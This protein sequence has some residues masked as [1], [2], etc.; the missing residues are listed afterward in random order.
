MN[1]EPILLHL[2]SS[3]FEASSDIYD[4]R[5]VIRV[6][7]DLKDQTCQLIHFCVEEFHCLPQ[8]YLVDSPKYGQLAHVIPSMEY[9]NLGSICVN[10]LDSVSVN[11][12]RPELAFEESLTRH[13]ALLRKL[14][15]DSDFNNQ[16][17]LR[18]YQSNWYLC[19]EGLI[20]GKAKRVVF[21]LSNRDFEE[22]QVY[23]SIDKNSLASLSASSIAL[24]RY[25]DIKVMQ[26]LS[27]DDRR[28]NKD[29]ICFSLPLEGMEPFVPRTKSEMQQW[30]ITCLGNVS[31]DVKAEFQ[32]N[33]SNKRS[34]EFWL[35]LSFSS[36]S[37]RVR[38]GVAL[39][40]YNKSKFPSELSRLNGWC[41][42]P[43]VV[44]M[45]DRDVL[46]PRS[47]A[48]LSLKDKRV[49]L[50]GCG[51]V[52]SEL[53]DKLGAS[54]VGHITLVDPD[55]Y[56]TS[57]LYRH[58]L[59]R[60]AI[61]WPK[62]DA[63]ASSLVK[64][65]PWLNTDVSRSKLLDFRD[66]ELIESFDLILIAI[67]NPTH[68][69][70]FQDYLDTEKVD[71]PVV[72]TW[73]EGYG[74]GGHAVLDIPGKQGCLRC[75][76]VEPD[77]GARGLASNLNFLEQDQD[78]VKNYAGCGE[79]F[80]PYGAIS[81][82]QTALIAADLAVSYLAG[83][84]SE[85]TK[86]SW[87]GDAQDARLEGLQLSRRFEFFDS[88]LKKQ[89]LLHPLCDACNPVPSNVYIGPNDLKVYIPSAI[90]KQFLSYRQIEKDMPEAAGLLIGLYKADSEIW[91]DSI[92]LPKD[93]DKRLRNYFRLD[94]PAHQKDVDAAYERT[95]QILGYVGTWHT[96]P[97]SVPSPSGVDRQDWKKHEE[98]NPDRALVF[99]V[100]GIDKISVYSSIKGEVTELTFVEKQELEQ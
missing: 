88:S 31:P 50:F 68:E 34:R 84:T 96:H 75:A 91:L 86:C 44:E 87:K 66:K 38:I 21:S 98:E 55:L 42:E 20:S 4:G 15:L 93:G 43:L 61:H 46:M 76:Y 48:T 23:R 79:M 32:R 95:D 17:L 80:I 41:I 28:Q 77:T 5:D 57:N 33:I 63:V 72:Y 18:E 94:A 62:L 59:N 19:T 97:Q 85:S 78:I 51:S 47:G 27:N 37:G 7:F 12:E 92:T 71:V 39:T 90:V 67:G 99:V 65:Y 2:L 9:A 64:K 14:I 13:V 53:S 73:L 29:V 56:S 16:E 49:L 3:E 26:Y 10:Q 83:R 22:L 54:G 40:N 69:R 1:Y 70:I 82:T 74:V 24:G 60:D 58:T 30:L 11:F 45:F 6:S 35:V 8:F 36:P 81:S 52:G 89:P 100:V 25:S